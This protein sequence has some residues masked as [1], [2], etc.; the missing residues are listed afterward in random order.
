[1][2]NE[3]TYDIDTLILYDKNSDIHELTEIT[4]E[5]LKENIMFKMQN[6]LPEKKTYRRIIDKRISGI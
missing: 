2:K 5:L 4:K 6:T 1:M 3:N